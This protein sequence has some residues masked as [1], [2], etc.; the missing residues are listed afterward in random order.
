[1]K[2]RSYRGRLKFEPP[3]NLG[4]VYE[5][6]VACELK[7]HG[8]DLFYYDNSK[9]GE[10]DFLV[11]D[12]DSLSIVPMEIKSGKDY[13]IHAALNR[14]VTNPDYKVKKAYV[15]SNQRE[16]KRELVNQFFSG[17]SM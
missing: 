11:N 6:A 2:D 1:M 10:V 8:H 5:T 3:I 16:S 17:L 7:A 14:F 4:S 9:K 12:Y 15:F 13:T